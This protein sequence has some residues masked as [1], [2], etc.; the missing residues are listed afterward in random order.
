MQE[1]RAL[2]REVLAEEL[3]KLRDG[4]APAARPQVR[5]EVV[6]L[7]S[8]ADLQAFVQR[9]MALAQDGGARAEIEAGRH[10]FRLGASASTGARPAPTDPYQPRSPAPTAA[11]SPVRFERGLIS[12]RDIAA[13][14][15]GQRSIQIA[16]T[17]RFTPL[18]RDELRRRGI[19]IERTKQ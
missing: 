6:D 11:P 4:D 3:A 14:P 16:K 2:I 17:V 5:E 7:R 13:L 12:E 19:K 15:D 1:M 18:A 10:V 8:S 9:I